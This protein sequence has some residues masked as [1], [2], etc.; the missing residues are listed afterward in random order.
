MAGRCVN[1]V[2]QVV[3]HNTLRLMAL[4]MENR[5]PDDGELRHMQDMLA[6][7]LEAGALG[8]AIRKWV[9]VS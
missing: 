2:M 5:A 8:L 4:G 9:Q 1:A 7:A 6:E 3:G